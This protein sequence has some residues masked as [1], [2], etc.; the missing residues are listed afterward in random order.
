[1]LTVSNLLPFLLKPCR[2]KGSSLLFQSSSISQTSALRPKLIR[3]FRDSVCNI[4]MMWLVFKDYSSSFKRLVLKVTIVQN[5]KSRFLMYF[6]QNIDWNRRTIVYYKNILVDY[7]L[8]IKLIFSLII[9]IIKKKIN[10]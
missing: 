6:C 4:K 1:M 10:K 9:S 3:D 8:F 5:L 7:R 2:I